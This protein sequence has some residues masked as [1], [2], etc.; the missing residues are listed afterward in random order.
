MTNR[1]NKILLAGASPVVLLASVMAANAQSTGTEAIETVVSTGV[2]TSI[3]GI[4]KPIEVAKERSTI[5]QSFLVTQVPGQSIA[6]LLNKGPRLHLHQ[7]RSLWLVGRRHPRPRPLTAT[8]S[9]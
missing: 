4:M 3:N 5:S 6:E 1:L 2:N 8:A 7:Q 9:R